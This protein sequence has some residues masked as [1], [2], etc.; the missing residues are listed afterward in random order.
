MLN[1]H[2]SLSSGASAIKKTNLRITISYKNNSYNY[3]LPLRLYAHQWNQEQAEPSN[4]YLKR[5]KALNLQLIALKVELNEEMYKRE[6]RDWDITALWLRRFLKDFFKRKDYCINDT[7]TLEYWMNLYMHEKQSRVKHNTFKR[8]K[9]FKHLVLRFEG[10]R[11]RKIRLNSL[12]QSIVT[13]F[14]N[15]IRQEQYQSSTA[16]RTLVFIRTILLFAKKREMNF[17]MHHIEWE[18]E[19]GVAEQKIILSHKELQNIEKQTLP[20]DLEQVK[21]WLLISCYTGQRVSDFMKFTKKNIQ[22]KEEEKY[23]DFVQQKTGKRVL[24]PIHPVVE[25]II[26]KYKGDFPK[27]ITELIYNKKLKK[28]GAMIGL[29]QFINSRKRIKYRAKEGEYQK[30]ELLSSHIGRRSFATNFYGKIP[31]ALLISATGHSSEK[32]FLRYINQLDMQKTK[33]LDGYFRGAV[34]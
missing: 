3:S 34:G 29:T 15:F 19:R 5:L 7:D 20:T 30:W 26:E 9:V 14:Q 8:Y 21:D 33:L 31:T 24:L 13:E 12:S 2:Y 1:I 16:H 27:P 10:F 22:Q 32:T 6:L 23:L 17:R 11:K 18:L 25:Q 28:L 4:I